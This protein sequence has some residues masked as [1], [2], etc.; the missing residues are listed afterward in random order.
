MNFYLYKDNCTHIRRYILFK[1]RSGRCN[2]RG[3]SYI[4]VSP[5]L[6]SK[7]NCVDVLRPV[8]Q[9]ALK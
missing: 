3:D 6:E 5:A 1:P 4:D 9:C 2:Q 8:R 7:R